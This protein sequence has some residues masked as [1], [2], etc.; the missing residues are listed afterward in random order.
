MGHGVSEPLRVLIVEASLE[1]AE[2]AAGVLRRAGLQV[3]T[4][5]IETEPELVP[6][7]ADFRPDLILS[8]YSMA[9]FDAMAVL[10]LALER[11]PEVP[12]VVVTRSL[13]EETA[14]DCIKAGAWDYVL[15]ANLARLPG[16]VRRALDLARARR[17][18]S[19]AENALRR[20]ENLLHVISD[21]VPALISYIG[22]DFRYVSV[23]QGYVDWFHRSPQEIVGRSIAEMIGDS[24]WEEVRPYAERTLAGEEVVFERMIDYPTIGPRSVR[25]SY[26]PDRDPAGRVQGFVAMVYDT[27]PLKRAEA[28]LREREERY[29]SLFEQSPIGIYRT[30]P[31]GRILLANPALLRMVGYGSLAEMAARNLEEAG[32]EPGYPR[33]RFK[34]I[35]EREGRLRDFEAIW[36]TKDGRPVF[37]VENAEAIRDSGGVVL[38]YEGTVE[39]VTARKQAEAALRTSQEQLSNAMKLAKL[40]YWEYDVASDRFT[41]NDQFYS[42][43]RTTAAAAG[44]YTLSSAEYAR[45]FVHPDD[46]DVVAAEIRRA[47]EAA[48]PAYVGFVEHRILCGD[49]EAGHIAVRFSIV[50]DRQGRT[51]RTF[52]ANQ[53]ITERVRASEAQRRLVTA[54][55]QTNEAV[56]ITDPGGTMTYV[57]PAFERITGYARSEAL[58]AN[59][60]MLKSD[61]QDAE[62]YRTMWQTISAGKV[63]AGHLVNRRKDGSLYDE[64]MTISPV[65]DERGT[66][67]NFVAVK[68]DVSR[69]TA[70]QRQ[71][72]HAQK[73][74]AVG[75][76]A[77]GIAHDF[78]N[79]LQAMLSQVGLLHH[80]APPGG[81]TARS[82]DEVEQLVRRGAALTRQLLLFSRQETSQPQRLDLNDAVRNA[83]NLLRRVVHENVAIVLELASASQP[84]RADPGQL[85]QVLVNLVVNA[86]DAMPAGGRVTLRT[87]G[88]AAMVWLAVIDTGHGIP[89]SA[90]A[91]LFEPFFTT[92]AA[93]KGTGLGLSVV[94]GIVS[95]HGGRVEVTSTVGLGTTF[96]VVLPRSGDAPAEPPGT[97]R[98]RPAAGMPPGRNERI[99]I[100]ED[101]DGA[102]QG[103]ADILAMLGYR[104]TAVASAEDAL[105]LPH[106]PPFD[107]VLSDLL[108][109]GLA[110]PE[111]VRRLEVRWPG[112]RIV[113]MSG[114]NED[115]SVRDVVAGGGVNFLQKPFDMPTL[116]ATIRLALDGGTV[117]GQ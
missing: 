59:P 16:A 87:G 26:T 61:V 89:E 39:D 1:D 49:G 85:D 25:V 76:L 95:A 22:S 109:P 94:H 115:E 111:L 54:V 77:G 40:G 62:F 82:F 19:D 29:R 60:S 51:V 33:E 107:L 65:R 9:G 45:R 98:P 2:L 8:D 5:R 70:L 67:V 106:A 91:H 93:G 74:D 12:F 53:D 28:A 10:R 37:V 43:Y 117:A 92:K 34:T 36:T 3:V 72:I 97:D 81:P 96:T 23:N 17:E 11:A 42:I 18:K 75:R 32:F 78:N 41:F 6:A 99:L 46:A 24:G 47:A 64:E 100:V 58:G 110:G 88:D 104:V 90:R 57:N 55:D 44:G 7:L 27:S 73:M 86:S 114:Y 83:A 20:Q 68:R 101:E 50:K 112:L 38:Y 14:V 30:T 105:A 69:E 71:L 108:L 56:I 21:A 15:K 35:L 80:A 113:L 79:L 103:L 4:R 52:G 63:W 31:D 116:A 66:I 84:L 102:R 13:D 48:D